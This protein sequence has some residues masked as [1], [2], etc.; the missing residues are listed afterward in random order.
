M[1]EKLY[2]IHFHIHMGY[3]VTVKATDEE[4]AM[5]K[6]KRDLFFSEPEDYF[7]IDYVNEGVTNVVDLKPKKGETK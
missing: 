2:T 4:M 7:Y 1:N 3:D 5:K 6:A